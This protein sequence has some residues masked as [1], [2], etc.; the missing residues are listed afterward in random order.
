MAIA[1][2]RGCMAMSLAF[3]L[4]I[5]FFSTCISTSR[6]VLLNGNI[7]FSWNGEGVADESIKEEIFMESH[8]S[9][10]LLA[11]DA[12]HLSLNAL[13]KPPVCNEKKY[14]NCL[15]AIAEDKSRCTYYNR[16]RS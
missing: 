13:G 7:N 12:P 1:S 6:A 9:Q 10:R 3:M 2:K 4:H 11:D 8:A 14:G 5:A 16:C 15:K